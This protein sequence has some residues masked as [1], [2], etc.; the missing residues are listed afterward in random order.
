VAQTTLAGALGL[1]SPA[2]QAAARAR[3]QASP[4]YQ[5]AVDQALDQVNRGAAA[6]GGIGGGNQLTALQDRAANLANQGWNS[7]IANLAS[8]GQTGFQATGQQAG[9]QT[10]LAQGQIAQGGANAGLLTNAATQQAAIA[11][12]TAQQQGGL[13]NQTGL[14]LAQ[15]QTQEAALQAQNAANRG[16]TQAGYDIG[17]ATALT[18]LAGQH[19]AGSAALYGTL[20]QQLSGLAQN[21]GTQQAGAYN[22][23]TGQFVNQDNLLTQ[24][25]IPMV[26][27]G[28]MAGQQASATALNF[29]LGLG[30]DL[31]KLGGL[32]LGGGSTLGGS[33]FSN[34]GGLFG[35]GA[36][37]AGGGGINYTPTGGG[38]YGVGGGFG[39]GG[40]AA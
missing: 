20:G 13:A 39:G 23:A 7:W 1:G 40:F 25:Q 34:I 32:G 2:D 14:T 21:Y 17:Q 29:G 33:L 4:G 27:Q 3:F 37:G 15:Q 22:T 36:Y 8:T 30:G 9:A 18:N 26:N 19:G 10:N 35:G 6:S 11:Q 31:L 24:Q 5:Y 16:T 28:G 12:A 38:A